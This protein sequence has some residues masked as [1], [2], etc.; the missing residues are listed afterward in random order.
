MKE[1]ELTTQPHYFDEANLK[2]YK[3][4]NTKAHRYH[5]I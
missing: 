3:N 4:K 5:N 1:L 2:K